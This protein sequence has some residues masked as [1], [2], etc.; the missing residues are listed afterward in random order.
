MSKDESTH[1][2]ESS[3]H[4]VEI[5]KNKLHNGKKINQILLSSNM[6]YAVTLSVEDE[7]ICEWQFNNVLFEPLHLISIA[8]LFEDITEEPDISLEAIANNKLIVMKRPHEFSE[9]LSMKFNDIPTMKKIQIQLCP[10]VLNE[11]PQSC[12]FTNY[13]DL[14]VNVAATFFNE[15]HDTIFMFYS[16]DLHDHCWMSKKSINCGILGEIRACYLTSNE[17]LFILDLC[18]LLTQWNLNTLKFENQYQLEWNRTWMTDA[19]QKQL[20]IFNNSFTLLAVC[21]QT[22]DHLFIAV[23]LTENAT[24]LSQCKKKNLTYLNFISSDEGERIL[25]FFDTITEIR[26]PYYLDHVIKEP[27][28]CEKFSVELNNKID[29]Q[30]ADLYLIKNERIYSV[31]EECILVQEFSKQQWIKF[32]RRKLEDY[33][34]IR[35]LLSKSQIEIFL[36]EILSENISKKDNEFIN[37]EFK[38]KEVEKTYNGFLVKWEV[39]TKDRESFVLRAFKKCNSNLEQWDQ[40]GEEREIH[41]EHLEPGQYK[42][43]YRCKLLDNEDLAMITVIGLLVWTVWQKKEIRLRYYKGFPFTSKYLKDKDYKNRYITGTMKKESEYGQSKFIMKKP[44]IT[45]LLKNILDHREN[46]L[47]P[48]DFDAIIP[49]YKELRMNKS[50]PFEELLDDYIE[51]KITLILYGHQLLRSLLNNKSYSM[52]ENLYK[53][54]MKINIEEEK[55]NFLTNIKLLEIISFSL[56]DLSQKFP[57][58][59]KEFLSYTSF[60]IIPSESED[61][62]IGN[63]SSSHL[64]NHR[65]YSQPFKI[66]FINNTFNFYQKI[67]FPSLKFLTSR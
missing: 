53:Q 37:N 30:K 6:N 57:D 18:G 43:V 66:S 21:F 4:V 8:D 47:P 27:N 64:Q 49:Y 2:F 11:D 19:L 48:P 28:L 54:C 22:P 58:I 39:K 50:Y 17:K 29:V 26:D 24:L 12:A 41:P 52:A 35:P 46:L 15:F 14:A 5:I 38:D 34:E 44:F 56:V 16:K 1:S 62:V 31:L 32:L 40:V 20:Y 65:K 10:D 55:I 63:F 45:R 33:N 9:S 13:G 25:L 67:K 42:F 3:H 23:Y 51:D 36:Q 61:L 59:L 60:T 7:S